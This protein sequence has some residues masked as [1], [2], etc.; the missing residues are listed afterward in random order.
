ML[1]IIFVAGIGMNRIAGTLSA[2]ALA[3]LAVPAGAAPLPKSVQR[4]LDRAVA[5]GDPVAIGQLVGGN[6]M[7]GVQIVAIAVTR[8]PDL[9]PRIAAAAAG[10]VPQVAPQLAAA[11]ATA[12]PQAA[13]QIAARVAVAVPAAR[14]AVADAVVGTLPP[15]DRMAAA[16][17][18]HAAVEA[19]ELPSTEDPQ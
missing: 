10:N 7:L 17:R 5:I 16:A 13:A 12:D 18:V 1:R 3:M 2:V 9:A 15:G 14:K 19:V 4:A 6:P 8:R 11:A